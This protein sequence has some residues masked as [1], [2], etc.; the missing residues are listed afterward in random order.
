MKEGIQSRPRRIKGLLGSEHGHIK[1]KS[2]VR[3]ISHHGRWLCDIRHDFPITPC[4]EDAK[5]P[6][7]LRL[8]ETLPERGVNIVRA[9]KVHAPGDRAQVGK[10]GRA[11]MS[12]VA[13]SLIGGCFASSADCIGARE[14]ER[15]EGSEAAMATIRIIKVESS[16]SSETGSGDWHRTGRDHA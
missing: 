14:W 5:V 4:W 3:S 1:D 16:D 9:V 11:T 2:F 15:R 8:P 10:V 7:N 13:C 6:R 12:Q